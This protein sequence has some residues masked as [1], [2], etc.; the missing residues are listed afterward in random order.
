MR[1]QS[2]TEIK[3]CYMPAPNEPLARSNGIGVMAMYLRSQL[4]G[5]VFSPVRYTM[6]ASNSAF[7]QD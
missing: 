5:H 6:E 3:C 7:Q 2:E 1:G 4:V